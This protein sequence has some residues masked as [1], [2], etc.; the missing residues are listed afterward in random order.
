MRSAAGLVAVLATL[1]A[2]TQAGGAIKPKPDEV[3]VQFSAYGPSQL[4]VLPGKTVRWTNV[5]QRTHTVTSD[6]GRFD[7]GHLGPGSQFEVTFNVPGTYRYHCTI[8][9]SIVGEVDVRRVILGPLPIAAVPVGDRVEFTGLT[10]DPS[11][12][13][14]IERRVTGSRFTTI[15]Q[16]KPSGNGTWRAE[17]PAAE[18]GDYRAAVGADVSEIRR[19]IVGVRKVEIRPTREGVEVSVTPSKPYAPLLVEEYLRERFGWWPVARARL[20]YVSEAEIRLRGRP[21]RVRVVLVDDDG[22]TPIAT[23]RAV[24][25]R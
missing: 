2:V 14:R 15:A 21:A 20:D 13:I 3:A 25:L 22:W 4:D 1:V 8:H 19:M 6:T 10:A 11:K 7:S 23:S 17:I 16:V 18:T 24:S 12:R 5:S 9:S